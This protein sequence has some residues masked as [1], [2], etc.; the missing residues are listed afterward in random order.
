MKNQY[1]QL[2]VL[3]NVFRNAL[4]KYGSDETMLLWD[5]HQHVNIIVFHKS[6]NS[7]VDAVVIDKIKIRMNVHKLVL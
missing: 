3:C 4:V 2:Q 7:H 6:G 1:W 5:H